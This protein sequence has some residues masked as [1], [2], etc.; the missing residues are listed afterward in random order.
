MVG[1]PR[2]IES[3]TLKNDLA[4]RALSTA[5]GPAFYVTRRLP[6]LPVEVIEEIIRQANFSDLKALIL[7]SR[8]FNSQASRR[9]FR[10]LRF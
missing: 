1:S 4:S 5:S 3:I 2:N 9:L 10:T 6:H 7:I 8:A